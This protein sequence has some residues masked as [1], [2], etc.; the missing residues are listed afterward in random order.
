MNYLDQFRIQ[1]G[2]LPNGE[3]EFEFEIDDKFFEQFDNSYIKQGYYQA[4][5]VVNKKEDML[6][7]DFTIAGTAIM[8]CDRCGQDM[9]IKTSSYNE[10]AV[11]F[12]VPDGEENEDII[13]ISPKEH[14]LNV[15]QFLY[16]Y[17]T[18]M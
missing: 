14:D 10:L 4:L 11:K 9:E 6:L 17:I 7:L 3:H 1:F 16:E 5:V 2:S 15:A 13:V 12:G 8:P 18:L